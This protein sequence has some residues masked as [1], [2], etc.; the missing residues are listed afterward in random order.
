V[1]PRPK[2]QLARE[3]LTRGLGGV[4][5]GDTAE[6]VAWLFL[7]LEAAIVSVAEKH[8][9]ETEK[10]AL[11]EGGG[12]PGALPARRSATRLLGRSSSAERSPQGR[13]I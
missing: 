5:A 4:M 8:G 7:S 13:N 10:A 6:A 1:S 3:H 12:S 2:H 9:L 11:E